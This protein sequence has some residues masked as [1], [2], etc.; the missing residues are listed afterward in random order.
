M[1]HVLAD[2]THSTV[3]NLAAGRVNNA[4][5]CLL[6][7]REL[8]GSATV[9]QLRAALR[10]WR[11]LKPPTPRWIICTCIFSRMRRRRPRWNG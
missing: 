1:E 4:D 3:T 2:L 11:P 5:A 7:L 6:L 8:G 9:G 10:S